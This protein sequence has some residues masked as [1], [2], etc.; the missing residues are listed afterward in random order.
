MKEGVLSAHECAVF[1]GED[2]NFSVHAVVSR[3]Y[4]NCPFARASNAFGDEGVSGFCDFFDGQ[5]AQDF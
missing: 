2:L 5:F 3:V 4:V 1:V